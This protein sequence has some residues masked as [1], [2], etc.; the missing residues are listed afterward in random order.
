MLRATLWAGAL[1]CPPDACLP[2]PNSWRLWAELEKALG[3]RTYELLTLY[4]WIPKEAGAMFSRH[5]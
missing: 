2:L 3:Q 4:D 5:S 1:G